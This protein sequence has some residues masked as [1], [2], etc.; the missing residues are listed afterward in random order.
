M[1]ATNYIQAGKLR[2]R[3]TILDLT[4]G[5]AGSQDSFG[6]IVPGPQPT[7]IADDLPAS[8]E[9]VSAKESYSGDQFVSLVTHRVTVRWLPGVRANQSVLFTDAEARVRTLQVLAVDNPDERN[10]MLI[11]SCQERDDSTRQI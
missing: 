11:L 1:P 9:F 6:G 5:V 2:Q 3:I 10:K 7:P 8:I 4:V